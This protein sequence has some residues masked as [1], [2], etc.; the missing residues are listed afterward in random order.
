MGYGGNGTVQAPCSGATNSFVRVFDQSTFK[1]LNDAL[2]SCIQFGYFMNGKTTVEI[3]VYI[4]KTGGDPDAASFRLLKS[5]SVDTINACG[6]FQ[7][8]TVSTDIPIDV[9]FESKKETLVIEMKTPVMSEGSIKGGG[10]FNTEVKNT[11]GQTYVGDCNGGYMTYASYVKSN[12]SIKGYNEYAQWYVRLHGANGEP[13]ETDSNDDDDDGL[14]S[15]AIAGI[16]IG[17]IVGVIAL[18]GIG[19]F[20]YSKKS[21]SELNDPLNKA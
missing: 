13:I 5:F 2:L 17:V 1:N 19:F 12:P 15:G 6:Q 16:S 4:D 18:G 9:D 3:N 7:V 21:K 8:Q 20:L 14:S 11:V 10:Q